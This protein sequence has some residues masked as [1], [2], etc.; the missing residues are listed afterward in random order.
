LCVVVVVVVVV[1]KSYYGVQVEAF[2]TARYVETEKELAQLALCTALHWR[3]V[4]P[5]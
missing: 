4:I 3:M 2:A 1:D 5:L